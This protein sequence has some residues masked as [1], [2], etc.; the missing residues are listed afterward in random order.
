M[1]AVIEPPFLVIRL[2]SLGDI[3]R[4][5]PALRAMKS[6]GGC[7]V[8]LTVEDRFA[9]LTDIFPLADR[10]IPYPRKKPGPPSRHPLEWRR[11]V[12]QYRSVLKEGRYGTAI[13][14]HGIARSAMVAKLS[15][16]RQ[17]AGYARGFGKEFSHLFYDIKI[18]PAKS[19]RISRF[20]RYAGAL[21]EL[22]LPSPSGEYF[23]PALGDSA[24]EEVSSFVREQGVAPKRYVFAFLGTSRAQ[25]HKR[26][27]AERFVELARLTMER[28]RIPTLLGWGPEEEELVRTLPRSDFLFPIPSWDLPRLLGAIEMAACFVGADTGAMHLAALMGVPTLAVL[29]P[30]DPVLNRPF[31]DRSRIIHR[32]GIRRACGGERC[33]HQECMGKIGAEE[34]YAILEELLE[35]A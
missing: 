35:R 15:G 17:S 25:A 30:T 19:T 28:A 27:P 5:L 24:R 10:V 20:E 21:R 14:L 12:R 26:W 8:D 32:E 29:G 31:G 13:D 23:S 3:A 2:S 22:G 16:A 7:A 33:P 34:T 9:P 6:Q 18:A 1:A 11:A 4:L